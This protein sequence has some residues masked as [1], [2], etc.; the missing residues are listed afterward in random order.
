MKTDRRNSTT[1]DG[2]EATLKMVGKAQTRF[3]KQIMAASVG[4]E[5]HLQRRAKDR[6]T[7]RGAHRENESL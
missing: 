2:E 4:R 7:H 5:L 3:G 6:R 1:K